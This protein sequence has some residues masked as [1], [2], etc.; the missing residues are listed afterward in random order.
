VDTALLQGEAQVDSAG[1][2]VVVTRIGVRTRDSLPDDDWLERRSELFDRFYAPTVNAQS[3]S[4]FT[5]LLCIDESLTARWGSRFLRSLAIPAELVVCGDPWEQAVDAWVRER[6]PEVLISSGLDSD[7]AV[8]VDFVE[9]VQDEIRPDRALNFVDG[10]WYSL[11]QR[12]FV[13]RQVSYTNPFLSLHSSSGAWVFD[14][15]GHKK[16]GRRHPVD[17]VQ[18]DPMWMVVVHEGNLSNSFRS[19]A[20]PYPARRARARFPAEFGP[21]RSIASGIVPSVIFGLTQSARRVRSGLARLLPCGRPQG[22]F[23]AKVGPQRHR[24]SDE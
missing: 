5:A 6:S 10:L 15:S 2:H 21:M 23:V 16:V 13:H 24:S 19:D 4:A 20:R 17:E 7:D 8:A 18:G 11:E 1:R 14:R 9:R 3:T 12:R 22:A